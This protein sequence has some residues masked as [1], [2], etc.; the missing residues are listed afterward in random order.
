MPYKELINIPL[1]S[2]KEILQLVAIL[3][4]IA[5]VLLEVILSTPS[6]SPFQRPEI[7]SKVRIRSNLMSVCLG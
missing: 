3:F 7:T 1:L 2:T 4:G 5:T 6:C